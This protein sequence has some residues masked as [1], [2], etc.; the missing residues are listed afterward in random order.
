MGL[1][2]EVPP[3][4]AAG[5]L[6][7]PRDGAGFPRLP[8]QPLRLRRTQVSPRSWWSPSAA[9]TTPLT[10]PLPI[11]SGHLR[12]SETRSYGLEPDTG[13]PPGR[14]IAYQLRE[15]RLALRACGQ[16]PLDPPQVEAEEMDPPGPPRVGH[17]WVLPRQRGSPRPR[18]DPLSSP[19]QAGGG[20]AAAVRGAGDGG[21][22]CCGECRADVPGAGAAQLPLSPPPHT[23]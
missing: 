10:P 5:A 4:S 13:G 21:G 17:P 19:G 15:V 6:L 18:T 20:G 3:F 9:P 12:L 22:P 11:A 7:L 2:P 16:G 23:P 8:G 1:A 14:H